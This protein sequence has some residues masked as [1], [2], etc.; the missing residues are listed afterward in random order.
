[1]MRE[2]EAALLEAH[3][4]TVASMWPLLSSRRE[5]HHEWL[6]QVLIPGKARGR[7][8]RPCARYSEAVD[9]IARCD[10]SAQCLGCV[11]TRKH[12][13]NVEFPT[14]FPT[15]YREQRSSHP[16]SWHI[17]ERAPGAR[18]MM[19]FRRLQFKVR[20]PSPHAHVRHRLQKTAFATLKEL[21]R[22]TLSSLNSLE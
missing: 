1:M 18:R 16:S 21:S 15:C 12:F 14:Q 11:K 22:R 3:Q 13:W 17:G 7:C 10:S 2:L 5:A 8:S 19:V 6:A 4:E 9:R 20:C